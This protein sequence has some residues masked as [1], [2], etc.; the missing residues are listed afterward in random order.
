MVVPQFE[1]KREEGSTLLP[2]REQNI[3]VSGEFYFAT[4]MVLWCREN[5]GRV[6]CTLQPRESVVSAV[7]EQKQLERQANAGILPLRQAQGQNDTFE[8]KFGWRG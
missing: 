8:V 2:Q 5:S 3:G 6:G 4:E 7:T 1:Q